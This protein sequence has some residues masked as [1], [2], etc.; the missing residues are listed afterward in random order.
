MAILVDLSQVIMSGVIVNLASELKRPNAD[1]KLLVKHMVITSLLHIKTEFGKKYGEMILCG[2]SRHYWRKD[3][4]PWYKG[5]R[6]HDREKSDLDWTEIFAAINE[7]KQDLVETFP[8]KL[9]E[10]HGAEADDVIGVLTKYWQTNELQQDG[11]FDEVPQ[12]IL[13]LSSDGDHAQLQKYPNVVQWNSQHKKWVKAAN[14]H[15]YLIEHILSGDA[16]DGVPNIMTGDKWA[17]DRANGVQA[18]RQKSFKKARLQAFYE[19]GIDACE[20][21]QE[22]IHYSRNNTLVN[23]DCIPQ[24]L[25]DKIVNTYKTYEVKGSKMKIMTYL[26][27]NRMKR[28]FEKLGEF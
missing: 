16:G 26:T 21:E 9:I 15:E 17:E 11:I 25:Y 8:W 23:Y 10:V 18:D 5:H 27:A 14:P 2:D 3:V 4:F 13:I 22:R 12:K 20:T 7:I 6:K 1:T 28:L 19:K 24:E